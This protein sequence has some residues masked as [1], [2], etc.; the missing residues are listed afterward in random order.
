MLSILSSYIPGIPSVAV[1]GIF[2]PRTRGA[3]VAAQGRFGLPQTGSVDAATWDEI[4]DQFSGIE[5]A[6]F[7]DGE[8]F[9]GQSQGNSQNRYARSTTITQ[10]PGRDLQMGN[11]DPI[12]QEVVR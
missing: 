5:N 12:S 8:I 3:V 4:Y 6:T 10:F 9:P 11:R 1:D 7:R 2:G